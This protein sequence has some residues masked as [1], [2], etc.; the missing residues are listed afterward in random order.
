MALGASKDAPFC[1]QP[2]DTSR[3]STDANCF[4]S[5]PFCANETPSHGLRQFPEM[6]G[7]YV[8]EFALF[9][10]GPNVEKIG[11]PHALAHGGAKVRRATRLGLDAR[12]VDE[13]KAAVRHQL[14]PTIR[15]NDTCD[16]H[17]PCAQRSLD[18]KRVCSPSLTCSR[19]FA[20]D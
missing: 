7:L 16:F 9:P 13:M 17:S 1:R 3:Q 14:D 18:R 20:L 19:C 4:N 6:Q 10:T 11:I 15:S 2:V 8:V 5:F 12:R